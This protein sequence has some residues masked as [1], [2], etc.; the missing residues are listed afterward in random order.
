MRVAI[1]SLFATQNVLF[2]VQ[3]SKTSER[4]HWLLAVP[5]HAD[6]RE[7]LLHQK[8]STMAALDSSN[9]CIQVT[10][11]PGGRPNAAH[12]VFIF[13]S[14]ILPK[15]F[16]CVFTGLWTFLLCLSTLWLPVLNVKW[17]ALQR[18]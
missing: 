18:D 16:V 6:V 5:L 14:F 10:V 17:L 7:P 3:A 12:N 2:P 11:L 8:V 1:F 15:V 13:T 4:R 9:G